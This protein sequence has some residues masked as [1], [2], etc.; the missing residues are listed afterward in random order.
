MPGDGD[1]RGQRVREVRGMAR[2]AHVWV[3]TSSLGYLHQS[4]WGFALGL[5]ARLR[6]EEKPSWAK[7][8]GADVRNILSRILRYLS[9]QEEQGR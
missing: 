4:T 1:F 7:Y 6:G 8:L 5:F 2:R 9:R 3:E